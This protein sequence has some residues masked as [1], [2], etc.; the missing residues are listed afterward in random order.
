MACG[1]QIMVMMPTANGAKCSVAFG[2]TV[3]LA[4]GPLP[5]ASS[6]HAQVP[7]AAPETVATCAWA[8]LLSSSTRFAAPAALPMA[9]ANTGGGATCV[10]PA[11]PEQ[12]ATTASVLTLACQKRG[13]LYEGRRGEKVS[14]ETYRAEK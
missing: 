8:D 7:P 10:P 2:G 13:A 4:G 9:C 12:A 5:V 3:M 11:V 1:S 6:T 14:R